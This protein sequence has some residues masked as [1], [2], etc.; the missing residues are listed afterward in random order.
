M[1]SK[2][3]IINKIAATGILLPY[4]KR[5]ILSD[6][7]YKKFSKSRRIGLSY[8]E[9]LR[10]ACIAATDPKD[11]G[12][13]SN[14]SSINRELSRTYI[15]DCAFWCNF[16]GAAFDLQE[17]EES[18]DF[19]DAQVFRVAFANGNVIQTVPNKPDAFRSKKDRVILDEFAFIDKAEE[20]LA[21]AQPLLTWPGSQLSIISSASDVTHPFHTIDFEEQGYELYE[22]TLDQAIDEGFYRLI[23]RKGKTQWTIA[24][25]KAWRD[26]LIKKSLNPDREF[27]CIPDQETGNQAF[28]A[29][30]ISLVACPCVE[31]TYNTLETSEHNIERTIAALPSLPIP[32]DEYT[33]VL[34]YDFGRKATASTVIIGDRTQ[35]MSSQVPGTDPVCSILLLELYN[36]PGP[37]QATILDHLVIN[38][39]ISHGCFDAT[40]SGSLAYD[41]FSNETKRRIEAITITT[42]WYKAQ[43]SNYLDVVSSRRFYP[44]EHDCT[45]KDHFLLRIVLDQF[46]LPPKMYQHK[47][48]SHHGEIL[49]AGILLAQAMTR[50]DNL[51]AFS[52]DA[53]APEVTAD[54]VTPPPGYFGRTLRSAPPIDDPAYDDDFIYAFS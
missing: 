45:L 11:G 25:E 15:E 52:T 3:D 41:N 1:K 26:D 4:Q 10:S 2:Y 24:G 42:S 22:T 46:V 35:Q 23:C 43:G 13:N 39:Q 34:G 38:Y 16:L 32:T 30:D 54:V 31:I 29:A 44:P 53:I 27:F 8:A 51:L 19:Y 18:S 12:A 9:A 14:Y 48:R 17:D 21:G 6:F 40:G 50:I 36:F 33:R 47:K 28:S 7:P 49:I 5:W 20:L 37:D